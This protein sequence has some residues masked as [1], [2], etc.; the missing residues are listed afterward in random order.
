MMQ[1]AR[2]YQWKE[3]TLSKSTY[4]RCGFKPKKGIKVIEDGNQ[5][6]IKLQAGMCPCAVCNHEYMW[7]CKDDDCEC[8]SNYCTQEQA[9]ATLGRW[10]GGTTTLIPTTSWAAPNAL[11]PTQARNDG[12]AY[13]WTSSTSTL[14]L[15][16]SDL[17]D[18]Y[19]VIARVN[20][21]DTSN[22]R[23]SIAGRFQQTGGTG[24]FVNGQAGGYSRNNNNDDAYI[25]NWAFIDNPSASATIQFQ[26]E[27]ESDAPTGGTAKSSLDVIPFYYADIGMYSGTSTSLYGGTTRN[28]VTID[29]DIRFKLAPLT[30]C[31]GSGCGPQIHPAQRIHGLLCIVS[32]SRYISE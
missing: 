23:V 17:A 25:S 6:I 3:V 4:D 24:N 30:R 27:R 16:S 14:T 22:G 9:M 13:T 21:D 7:E 12:S 26:W 29:R 5:V 8:C 11:F 1:R 20:Y 28:V 18:G 19:L 32:S 15:P 10:T 2:P 31:D